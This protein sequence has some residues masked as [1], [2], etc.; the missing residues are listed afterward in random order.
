MNIK[1]ILIAKNLNKSSTTGKTCFF[2]CLFIL[3]DK[4]KTVDTLVHIIQLLKPGCHCH[5]SHIINFANYFRQSFT[6]L[7]EAVDIGFTLIH[8]SFLVSTILIFFFH[9]NII[10]HLPL[11]LVQ[12]PGQHDALRQ[13]K[14][15]IMQ[16]VGATFKCLLSKP[17]DKCK[18][19]NKPN[20][21]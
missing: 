10:M 2:S 3:K 13:L 9:M 6:A 1:Y 19:N 11:S 4:I 7:K 12:N 17:N 20:Y 5:K 8:W 14:H 21:K 15:E 16:N 18:D